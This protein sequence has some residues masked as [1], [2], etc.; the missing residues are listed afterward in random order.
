MRRCKFIS[1]IGGAAGVL[2]LAAGAQQ[3]LMPVIGRLSTGSRHTDDAFRLP[4]F[5]LGLNEKGYVEGR[6]VVPNSNWSSA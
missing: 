6:N 2:P 5:R 4:P 1:L 3:S